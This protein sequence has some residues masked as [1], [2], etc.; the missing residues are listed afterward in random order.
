MI[1]RMVDQC[2]PPINPPPI[3][4]E[5]EVME[6]VLTGLSPK[7]ILFGRGCTWYIFGTLCI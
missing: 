3:V 5:I 4:A 2:G 1:A 7:S 6:S